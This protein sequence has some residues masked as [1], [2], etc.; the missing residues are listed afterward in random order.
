MWGAIRT[1]RCCRR[2]WAARGRDAIRAAPWKW[3]SRI[4]DKLRHTYDHESFAV[5]YLA[6]AEPSVWDERHKIQAMNL[7]TAFH[8]A[9]SFVAALGTV[10]RFPWR[11]WR[12]HWAQLACVAGLGGLDEV[13]LPDHD[14]K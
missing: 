8:H 9:L 13:H 11:T 2:C 12:E 6:E 3:L 5:A 10:A 1:G 4:S 14:F 7:M